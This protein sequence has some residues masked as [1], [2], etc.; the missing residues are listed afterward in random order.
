MPK[1]CLVVNQN[2][3]IVTDRQCQTSRG[4][5]NQ[6][7]TEWHP[8]YRLSFVPV[9]D[10]IGLS[11]YVK[12]MKDIFF[13]KQFGDGI[14]LTRLTQG[15]IVGFGSKIKGII[16]KLILKNIHVFV[17]KNFKIIAEKK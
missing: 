2:K 4:F 10:S 12:N 14:L 11:N 7:I 9:S 5:V 17:M 13:L 3:G 16:L 15:E 1:Q 8:Y 6:K